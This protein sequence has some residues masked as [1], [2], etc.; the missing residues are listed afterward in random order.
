[1]EVFNVA[2]RRAGKSLARCY[3]LA[4]KYAEKIDAII[5]PRFIGNKVVYDIQKNGKTET[6]SDLEARFGTC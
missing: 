1:M 2:G 5:V 3:V 4:M 6:V